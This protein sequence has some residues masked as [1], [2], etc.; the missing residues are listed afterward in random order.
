MPGIQ[1][2][3]FPITYPILSTRRQLLLFLTLFPA[4]P[5]ETPCAVCLPLPNSDI[6]AMTH[7][8][9]AIA[10]GMHFPWTAGDN[11]ACAEFLRALWIPKESESRP[12]IQLLVGSAEFL[13]SLT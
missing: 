3:Y 4:V 1:T 8:F 7:F 10:W 11:E 9:L 5:H 2:C 6:P 12:F 13:F